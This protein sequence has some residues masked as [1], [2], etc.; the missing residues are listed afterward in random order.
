[1]LLHWLKGKSRFH[2]YRRDES[3]S[4]DRRRLEHRIILLPLP[5]GSSPAQLIPVQQH[6]CW[7]TKMQ[8]LC[9]CLAYLLYLPNIILVQ[10]QQMHS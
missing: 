3:T 6:H 5:Y 7:L 2:L 4:H 1:M 10:P 9:I 8:I